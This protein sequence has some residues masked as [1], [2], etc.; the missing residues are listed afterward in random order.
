MVVGLA[1][2]VTFF[3]VVGFAVVVTFFVVVGFAV[4]AGPVELAAH[5]EVIEGL[6]GVFEGLAAGIG[7]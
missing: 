5:G 6:G 7:Q 2:V 1:V 4:V 3:V